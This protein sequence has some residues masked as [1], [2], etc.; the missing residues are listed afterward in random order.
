MFSKLKKAT[1]IVTAGAIMAGT[2]AANVNLLGNDAACLVFADEVGDGKIYDSVSA[3]NYST[4]L[5]RGVDFGI[6]ADR[7]EQNQHMQTTFAVNT[8]ANLGQ[9]NDI[10]LIPNGSVA[11]VLIGGVDVSE[12]YSTKAVQIGSTTANVVNIECAP[13]IS[14]Y[15]DL[16]NIQAKDQAVIT[17]NPDTGKNIDRIINNVY[18]SSVEL[19]RKATNPQYAIDYHDYFGPKG[20]TKNALDLTD[21]KFI[22]KVVYIDVDSD[23]LRIIGEAGNRFTIYKDDS[24]VVVFNISDDAGTN[25]TSSG[26]EWVLLGKYKVF[27]RDGS[28]EA[29]SDRYSGNSEDP[30]NSCRRNDRMIC[31]KII[32]NIR[33][34]YNVALDNTSG[35]FI[36]PNAPKAQTWG[37]CAGWVVSDNFAN[38][39]GEWHYIYHGG[40]QDVLRDGVGQIHFAARKSFTHNWDGE[41]T[42]EDE[43]IYTPEHNYEFMWYEN[44]SSFSITDPGDDYEP[45]WNNATNKLLFPTLQFYTDLQKA[46][47]ANDPMDPAH[48]EDDNDRMHYVATEKTYYYT[49][50]EVGAGTV[51]ADDV[52][53][54]TGYINIELTVK[55]VAGKLQFYAT[56]NTYLGDDAHTLYKNNDDIR[57]SGVEF[58]M[59]A[60]FNKTDTSLLLKK[61]VTGDNDDAKTADYTFYVQD[62]S[63]NY[64]DADG[65]N[66]GQ[67]KTGITV[68]AGETVEVD[69]LAPGNY[70]V[71]EDLITASANGG[72]STLNAPEPTLVTVKNSSTPVAE[73]VNEYYTSSLKVTKEL[74]G[75]GKDSNVPQ[76]IKDGTFKFYIESVDHPGIYLD[77]NGNATTE[78]TLISIKA[79]ETFE[80]NPGIDGKFK[81]TEDEASAPTAQNKTLIVSYENQE[82]TISKD[83]PD[84]ESTIV[85]TYKHNDY[86]AIIIDKKTDGIEGSNQ[87]VQCEFLVSYYDDYRGRTIYLDSEGKKQKIQTSNYPFPQYEFADETTAKPI[88][89]T[90]GTP[91]EIYRR[92]RVSDDDN[93]VWGSA[94]NTNGTT[95][96]I[97]EVK[98]PDSV[99]DSVYVS[100]T[101]TTQTVT[102][103][104]DAARRQQTAEVTNHYK[105]TKGDLTITKTVG[106][107]VTKSE[108][109]GAL[110]FE[111]TRDIGGTTYYLTN[112]GRLVTEKT[113]LKLSDYGWDYDASTKTW[114]KTWTDIDEGDYSV[115]ETNTE[116][117]IGGDSSAKTYIFKQDASKTTDSTTLDGGDAATLELTDVY[118]HPDLYGSL[119]I[120]KTVEGPVTEEEAEGALT[121]Q[122]KTVIDGVTKY[123]TSE[124][125]LVN[126]VTTLKL[127]DSCFEDSGDGK[128]TATFDNLHVGKYDIKETNTAIKDAS[129]KNYTFIEESSVTVVEGATLAATGKTVDLK[130]VYEAPTGGLTITKT[131]EGPVTEEEAA[132]A[133]TFQVTTVIEGVTKY[134]TSDGNLVNEVTT[135]KLSDSCFKDAGDGKWTATFANL[136][137]GSYTVREIDTAI[138]DKDGNNYKFIKDDSIIVKENVAVSTSGAAQV[139]LKD[140]YEAP[141]GGLVITKT[142][143][144]PVTEE[145]AAG[146]LTFQVTTVIE[147]VTKYLTKDGKL[148]DEVTTLKLSDSCFEDTGDGKWTATFS[149]LPT[150]KYNVTEINTAIKDKDGNNYKFIMDDSITVKENVAVSTASGATVDLKDVYEAPTGGLVITK[151]VVGPVTEEEAAGALTF[152]VTTVI[153]GVTKYL[154]K[155]GKLVDEV[156]TLKLS[157]SCFE[158]TGDGKWTATFSNLPTGKYNVTE[159][160]TA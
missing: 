46:K 85:N 135:L 64:Y 16:A 12:G 5:G 33:S 148:V 27:N 61:T 80:C 98:Y 83:N 8:Y 108:A 107:P 142:V 7:F 123:L 32:W 84:A 111:V 121:F 43:T 113:T 21:E 105:S 67:L 22:N 49:V 154:T 59:G 125:K 56:T 89:V 132:G 115:T 101:G 131:V 37:T 88:V 138:K 97:K 114:T 145:E 51:N 24:T 79:G 35:L 99:G 147:G 14:Q 70:Y 124:G 100:T 62:E 17:E 25:K 72:D 81:I 26:E 78:K 153:E 20:E 34:S 118:E 136:P 23:L 73:L 120:T 57:V 130:D 10:D 92:D 103:F 71:S 150:G 40:S 2:F 110:T 141:T 102:L 128:W 31:Q 52:S 50:R 39:V 41:N 86:L 112:D 82:F 152:Q 42:V 19:D 87:P 119:T 127:S 69:N 157:D 60:F 143:V 106:G 104:D 129:G 91:F 76:H 140:V 109:E 54:S 53:I 38:K 158:D 45:V 137:D 66:N 117:H 159:I 55:N 4:I 116:I 96:T 126:E 11:Q 15:F 58:S 6:V 30:T 90:A 36:I 9:N 29:E 68:K 155:D 95:Y 151:T 18:E 63:F 77:E 93:G 146:A 134:L 122:V 149:N 13:G 139:D 160:N 74:V 47:D 75:A 133:L 48:P 94:H 144:G 156:T 44:D 65:N 1:A 3:V 28:V